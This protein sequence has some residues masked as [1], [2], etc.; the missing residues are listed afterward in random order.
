MSPRAK[1]EVARDHLDL[2]RDEAEEGHLGVVATFLL[3][4]S[5]AALDALADAHDIS[6]SP[7]H[8]RREQI[9]NELETTDVLESEDTAELVRL[10]NQQRKAY[11]YDG[12]EPDFGGQHAEDVIARVE[13]LVE[14][15][16]EAVDD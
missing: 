12:D 4:A 10:L 14:A 11:A 3:H 1:H 9:A 15:A 6:R 5:E 2:A 7:T 16:E 13:E 8:W